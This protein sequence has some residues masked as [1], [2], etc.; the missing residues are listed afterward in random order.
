MLMDGS[1]ICAADGSPK[2]SVFI[3]DRKRNKIK[4]VKTVSVPQL[5]KMVVE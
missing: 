1:E 5:V 3:V 2:E 4:S